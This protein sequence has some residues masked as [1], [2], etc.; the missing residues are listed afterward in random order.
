TYTVA[1]NLARQKLTFPAAGGS[2]KRLDTENGELLIFGGD[3][4]YPTAS[5]KDYN[6]RLVYPYRSASRQLTPSDDDPKPAVF[7]IPGNHD[8]YDSLTEFATLFC[9]GNEFAGWQ[10]YQNRSYFAVKLPHGWW[11]FGTDMQLASTLDGPQEHYFKAIIDNHFKAGDRII[12]CNAEPWW[13]TKEMYKSDPNYKNPRMGFF[14]GHLLRDRIAIHIAGDRHYYKRHEEIEDDKE[15]VAP[16]NP[17]KRQKIVAGGGGAFLHPTHLENVDKIGSRHIYDLKASF[18]SEADSSSLTYKNLGFLFLN[19]KFGI[20]TGLLYLLV[21]Q[22]FAPADLGRFGITEWWPALKAVA[23]TATFYPIATLFVALIFAA[24]YF[25]TDTHTKY[26]RYAAGP[27]H[28]AV[29]L[30]AIFGLSWFAAYVT[31]GLPTWAKYL[32]AAGIVYLGGHILGSFI[33]GVYLLLS[34]QGIGVHHNEAFSALK[35]AD[36]KNFLRMRIDT[37]GD[38]TIFPIGIKRANT[39]WLNDNTKARTADWLPGKNPTKDSDPFLIEPPITYA[40]PAMTTV[41]AVKAATIQPTE[42]IVAHE[43]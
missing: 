7:A 38:L 27:I 12:L 4:V 15:P 9:K 42:S 30:I 37:N 19:L 13:I 21:F 33:M 18:P 11:I 29:N 36:F 1:Y 28:A 26:W 20:V 3:E 14:E 39:D 40:K 8:W 24:F 22:A 35:I 5:K 10:T 43:I 25:F 34:L 17:S 2:E 32:A 23:H 41:Q 6:E 31:S 16:A